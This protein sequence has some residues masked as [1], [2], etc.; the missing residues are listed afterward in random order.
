LGDYLSRATS[1]GDDFTAKISLMSDQRKSRWDC[2]ICNH[3]CEK[4]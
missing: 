3:R 4:F 2:W 1:H